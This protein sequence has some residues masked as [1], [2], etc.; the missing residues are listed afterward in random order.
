MK[1]KCKKCNLQK[2]FEDFS[3]SKATKDQL[4]Y[5]CKSCVREI[6]ATKIGREV[7]EYN[8]IKALSPEINK[9]CGK[10]KNEL[11]FEKFSK[12]KNN[13]DGYNLW[14]KECRS[15]YQASWVKYKP[16]A[17]Y[18]IAEE[19]ISELKKNRDL[20]PTEI[21]EGVVVEKLYVLPQSFQRVK[22]SGEPLIR[23]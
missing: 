10:C 11:P 17:E 21:I 22:G 14:C 20:K 12:D 7:K 6:R 5:N 2:S 13:Y 9:V 23:R 4:Q 1:K 15:N 3:K 16:A 8:K 18:I 19:P